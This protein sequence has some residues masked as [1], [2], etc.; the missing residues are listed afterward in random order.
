MNFEHILVTTDFSD[1]SLRA[2]DLAAYEAKMQKSKLTL[3]AIVAD[4]DVPPAFMYDIAN[5]ESITKYREEL[6]EKAE[7]KL[8][9]YA[10]SNFHEETV[11]PVA[12]L[13]SDPVSK[14]ICDYAKEH[15]VNLIVMSSHGRGAVGSLLVGS[16][17]QKVIRNAPCP[18]MVVPQ[19]N[20]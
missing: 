1:N 5:P 7:E 16:T 20:S 14:V 9:E 11:T 12:V 15:N 10:G 2:F 13:S 19:K 17:V 18:V 6:R 3:L 4:W 8:K